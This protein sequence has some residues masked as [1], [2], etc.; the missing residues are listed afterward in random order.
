VTQSRRSALA[1]IVA[2]ELPAK[3]VVE[4]RG[5]IRGALRRPSVRVLYGSDTR[6]LHRENGLLFAFDVS[7]VMYSSGNLAERAR[8]ARLDLTRE[9]VVDFFAGIGYFA[10][11]VGAR[12]GAARVFACEKNPEAY[13]FLVENIRLNG[14]GQ[15]VVPLLGDC[16]S[17]APRGVADRV[18]MGYIGGTEK[19]LPAAIASLK[20]SGGVIHYHEAYPQETKFSDAR[21][22]LG[23]AACGDWKV[24]FLAE[25]EVKSFAPGI[26]HVVVDAEYRPLGRRTRT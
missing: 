14:A 13:G 20:P 11:P 22:A 2:Q 9:T 8:M 4:D 19:F 5:G 26:D 17:V 1:R 18:I 24:R 6:A 15:K 7:R 16:R 21:R 10:I 25:R 3:T 12:T 23:R